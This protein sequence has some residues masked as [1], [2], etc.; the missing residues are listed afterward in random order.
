MCSHLS[1]SSPKKKLGD[2]TTFAKHQAP[3]WLEGK[4]KQKRIRFLI[5]LFF[6]YLSNVTLA[7]SLERR[8]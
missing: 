4:T 8:L 7:L 5:K 1:T 3:T 6:V 2:G